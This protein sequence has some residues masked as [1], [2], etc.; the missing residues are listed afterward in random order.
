M[1]G[2]E[3]KR[4]RTRALH[5]ALLNS[6]VQAKPLLK[7]MLVHYANH[8]NVSSV[9]NTNVRNIGKWNN[10]DDDHQAKHD[11]NVHV[12][13]P[14][15]SEVNSVGT[16][17]I[18]IDPPISEQQ[19]QSEAMKVDRPMSE[20][21]HQSDVMVEDPPISKQEEVICKFSQQQKA[22]LIEGLKMATLLASLTSVAG[23]CDF[24]TLFR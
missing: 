15:E 21:E 23:A 11:P 14:S 20:V 6:G 10:N 13:R 4:E 18:G 16:P 5:T 1:F 9:N 8:N 12:I 7:L 17:P 22:E 19:H 24:F 2:W 3:Y